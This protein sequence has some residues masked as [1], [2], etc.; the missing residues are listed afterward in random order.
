MRELGTRLSNDVMPELWMLAHA[1]WGPVAPKDWQAIQ[2]EWSRL[3]LKLMSIFEVEV[4]DCFALMAGAISKANNLTGDM[5]EIFSQA[6][7]EN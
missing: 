5:N 3:D 7:Q 2:S 6:F 4:I 1:F